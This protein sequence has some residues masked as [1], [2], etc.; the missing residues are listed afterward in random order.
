[1]PSVM[2]RSP[3]DWHYC[4]VICQVSCQDRRVTGVKCQVTQGKCRDNKVPGACSYAERSRLA[5][6]RK[7]Q[8][9]V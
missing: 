4:R 1:M 2:P 6:H 7:C 3:R 9:A 5:V 8:A